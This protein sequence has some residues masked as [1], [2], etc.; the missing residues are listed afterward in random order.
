MRLI[1]I[2]G[3][4]RTTEPDVQIAYCHCDGGSHESKCRKSG[5]K[6]WL[7]F[8]ARSAHY[9][10]AALFSVTSADTWLARGDIKKQTEIELY[11]QVTPTRPTLYKIVKNYLLFKNC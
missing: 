7:K 6:I 9:K 10:K 4:Q 5:H 2:A 8:N 1:T 3:R 11:S